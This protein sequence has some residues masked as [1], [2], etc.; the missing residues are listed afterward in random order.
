MGLVWMEYKISFRILNNRGQSA[1][2]YI[3]LMVVL[4]SL[5]LSVFNSRYFKDFF[6]EDGAFFETI[7][8]QIENSYRNALFVEQNNLDYNSPHPSFYDAN[9]GGGGGSRFFVGKNAYPP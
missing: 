6:D 1:V 8:T 5:S 9:A 2:E 3:L 4:I 7:A